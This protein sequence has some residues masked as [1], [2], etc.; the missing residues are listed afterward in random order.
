MYINDDELREA[1]RNLIKMCN[2]K[3]KIYIS[4]VVCDNNRLTLNSHFSENLNKDYSVI[5]RTSNEYKE[6]W[7]IFMKEGFQL[8]E[9]NWVSKKLQRETRKYYV[10]L[11]R[12]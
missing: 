3:C 2:T 11:Q 4:E 10:L 12:E 1:I 7:S 8:I 5:Y 9:E 6:I